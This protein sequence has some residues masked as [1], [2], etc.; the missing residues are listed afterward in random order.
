MAILRRVP[1]LVVLTACLLPLIASAAPDDAGAA[2]TPAT[3]SATEHGAFNAMLAA[4][5]PGSRRAQRLVGDN[6][7]AEH[8]TLQVEFPFGHPTANLPAL[9][10]AIVTKGQP[11]FADGKVIGRAPGKGRPGVRDSTQRRCSSMAFAEGAL[12]VDYGFDWEWRDNRNGD[13]DGKPGWAL[14]GVTLTVLDKDVAALCG[15]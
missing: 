3:A 10:D 4:D 8:L 2:E 11:A 5:S 1:Q 12:D 14:V 9:H 15:A 7:L 13:S 6:A